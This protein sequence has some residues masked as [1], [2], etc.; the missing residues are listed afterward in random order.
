MSTSTMSASLHLWS[1]VQVR[2]PFTLS[3]EVA[4]VSSPCLATIFGACHG[5]SGQDVALGHTFRELCMCCCHQDPRLRPAG[6]LPCSQAS[7][8]S[9]AVLW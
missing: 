3:N 2:L 1:C 4:G 9:E 8:C 7:G 5:G 6:G